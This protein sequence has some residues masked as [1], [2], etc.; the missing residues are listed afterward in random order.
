MDQLWKVVYDRQKGIP[1]FGSTPPWKDSEDK[2]I[3]EHVEH[4]QGVPQDRLEIRYEIRREPGRGE[5]RNDSHIRT[6]VSRS[7]GGKQ[8]LKAYS[9]TLEEAMDAVR[10]IIQTGHDAE[11]RQA[12]QG[13][14]VVYNISKRLVKRPDPAPEGVAAVEESY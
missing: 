2:E 9:M 14:Y 12:G 11:V 13:L 5:H 7:N 10:E 3:L 6:G 4:T 1:Y 8:M